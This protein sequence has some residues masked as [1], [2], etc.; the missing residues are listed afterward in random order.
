MDNKIFNVN[1]RG[2]ENLE[3]TLEL[4]FLQNGNNTTAKSWY[5]DEEKGLILQ[6]CDSVVKGTSLLA[7]M[8]ASLITPM[9]FKWVNSD[10]AK[11][12]KLK[13]WDC[14]HQH[15]GSNSLGWRVYVEDWGHVKSDWGAICAITPAYMWHGK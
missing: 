14:D 3:R 6:W 13:N 4:C 15:D 10:E 1:G 11:E 9:I 7:P 5:V 8:S 2:I 12:I